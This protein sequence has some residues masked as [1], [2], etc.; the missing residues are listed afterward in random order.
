MEVQQQLST[1][2]QRAR[3]ISNAKRRAHAEHCEAIRVKTKADMDELLALI[4]LGY[5]A[6][7]DRISRQTFCNAVKRHAV[8]LQ[9][10]SLSAEEVQRRAEQSKP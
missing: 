6:Q 4:S 7:P 5:E 1:E 9:Y 8:K 3:A 2:Q 10:G